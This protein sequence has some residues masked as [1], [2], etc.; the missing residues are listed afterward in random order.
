MQAQTVET[1]SGGNDN[2]GGNGNGKWLWEVK[3]YRAYGA[4]ARFETRLEAISHHAAL[5]GDAG[6]RTIRR[7]WVEV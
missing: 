4:G 6:K 3:T 1:V 5:S 7:V 2:G